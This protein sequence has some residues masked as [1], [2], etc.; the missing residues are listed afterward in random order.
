[1]KP[2]T[3]AARS[4]AAG[5]TLLEIMIALSI[6]SVLGYAL[7]SA[8]AISSGTQ[9][10]VNGAS[11]DNRLLRAVTAQLT[12]EFRLTRDDLIAI[13]VLAD[14]NHEVTFQLPIL[15]LGAAA[16]GVPGTDLPGTQTPDAANWSLR[17]TVAAVVENGQQNRRLIRQVLDETQTI[18]SQEVVADWLRAGND[19]WPGFNVVQTGDVWDITLSMTD[20]TGGR[21]ELHVA[22]RN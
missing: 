12:N 19:T 13:T 17:Y 5:Y 11:E 10:A 2:T 22:T 21:A 4:A 3:N 20:T 6:F 15:V 7:M 9:K 16:W 8:L 14:Q 1:M 18:R